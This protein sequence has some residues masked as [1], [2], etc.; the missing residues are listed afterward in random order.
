MDSSNAP[1]VRNDSQLELFDRGSTLVE[2]SVPANT[3][4]NE[5]RD[6]GCALANLVRYHS[7]RIAGPVRP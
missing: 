6:I 1:N 3:Q 7:Q 2:I 5:L 4:P